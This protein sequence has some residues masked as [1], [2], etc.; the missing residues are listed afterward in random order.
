M[1]QPLATKLQSAKESAGDGP[2]LHVVLYQPEI[3]PN[4]GNIGRSCV[5][6][7]A[8]LWLVRPLG[9]QTGEKE[10]RRAGLDYW[11][12]LDWE[13]VENWQELTGGWPGRCRRAWC[14]PDSLAALYRGRLPA[15]RRLALGNDRAACR[16]SCSSTPGKPAD[17]MRDDVAT[18]T[19]HSRGVMYEAVRQIEPGIT[20]K[21]S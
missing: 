13:A 4:T 19:S 20:A 15:G 12:H 10:L 16:K 7:G 21:W 9:F 8:K 14:S 11:S 18:S 2:L 1:E 17:S 5:A 3:P 6:I